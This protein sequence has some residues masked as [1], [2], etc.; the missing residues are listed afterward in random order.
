MSNQPENEIQ[1][2]Q[3]RHQS[4]LSEA[5]VLQQ[6]LG[7]LSDK[8]LEQIIGGK[9]GAIRANLAKVRKLGNP[10]S[11][12]QIKGAIVQGLHGIRIRGN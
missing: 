2:P 12:R 10:F 9:G 5:N 11:L 7:E 3:E 6:V 8:E 4:T 1:T